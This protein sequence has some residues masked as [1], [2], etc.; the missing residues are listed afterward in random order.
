VLKT[1]NLIVGYSMIETWSS[2]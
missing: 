1:V 2:W